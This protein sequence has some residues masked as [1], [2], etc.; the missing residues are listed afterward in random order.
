MSA[1]ESIAAKVRQGLRIE[2]DEALL[3]FRSNRLLEIGELA[4]WVN[5]KKNGDGV[6]FNV[7]RHI[8]YTNICENRCRFC[9]FSRTGNEADAYTLT[10]DEVVSRGVDACGK[11]ATEVHIVGGLNPLLPLDYYEQFLSG[12]RERCPQ[13]HIKAFTAVEVDFI[14]R[15]SGLPVPEVLTRLKE[16]GLGSL[17]GGG[18]EILSPAVRRAL[19]PEK[20][21]GDRWLQVMEQAHLL[22]IRSNAT[23]LYGHVETA[24]DRVNHLRL[25]RELQD[26]TGGFQAFVPLTFQPTNTL[27]HGEVSPNAGG[28][29]DLKTLAVARIYLDNFA[30][31]KAYW[32]MLGVKTAQV[33]LAFGVNDLDGTVTEEKIGHDAGASSPKML[34]MEEIIRL[35][36]R[37]GKVPV[38]RS[39]LYEPLREFGDRNQ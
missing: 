38:E 8:N 26:R 21:S 32:V 35:I 20:I 30:N 17:P 28:V 14:S 36:C 4:A 11:G 31:V 15:I 7:N 23:M 6:F 1:F 12:I 19:C 18:A 10:V 5:R 13:L 33:A 34:P 25:L 9:A 27:L 2:D 16:A 37:A 3:L 22:G 29:D 39:S 24:E